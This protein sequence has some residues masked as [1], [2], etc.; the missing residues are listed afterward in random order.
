MGETGVEAEKH[1]SE[2][3]VQTD[4]NREH[5]YVRDQDQLLKA[6]MDPEVAC[7]L[8]N[9]T[10]RLTQE[11]W[12]PEVRLELLDLRADAIIKLCFIL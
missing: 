6:V 9:Q 10:I 12:G 3:C 7:V 2:L 8:V 5:R 4:P 11:G 1:P